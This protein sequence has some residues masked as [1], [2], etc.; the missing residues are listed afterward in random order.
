MTVRVIPFALDD[1]PGAGSAMVYLGGAVTHLDTVIRDAPHGTAFVDSAAQL[2]HF[3]TLFRRVKKA[4]LD[5]ERS[6]DLIHQTA[7]EL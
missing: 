7:K 6:R 2:E 5:P 3:R 4:A 1:F